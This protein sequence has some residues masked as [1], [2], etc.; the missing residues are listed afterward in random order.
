MYRDALRE[1]EE[2]INGNTNP[3]SKSN[4]SM[5]LDQHERQHNGAQST[6]S[7]FPSQMILMA[8]G[9]SHKTQA[10]ADARSGLAIGGLISGIRTG[11][12]SR[13]SQ[14]K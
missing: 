3:I 1:V 12:E 10:P 14:V 2:R 5:Q 4:Y 6:G 9:M 11:L 13:H 8:G 7:A